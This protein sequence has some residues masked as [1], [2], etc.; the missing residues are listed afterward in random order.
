MAKPG[1]G[2]R[3]PLS[4]DGSRQY[5]LL[6]NVRVHGDPVPRGPGR[7]G[8]A[9]PVRLRRG[10]PLDRSHLVPGGPVG[11]LDL[12][13][14]V[15]NDDRLVVLMDN[16]DGSRT[17]LFDGFAQVPEL[18]LSPSQELVTFLAFG[19]AVREWD[20][21]IG[22]ALM[23]DADDPSTVADVETD[24]VTHF[25]PE[26]Q[27]N[28]TPEGADA[29]DAFGNTYPTFLDPL[30]VR[31]PDVRRQWTLPMAVRYLCYH[32][33]PDQDYVQNPDGTLLDALLDSRAPGAGVTFH[34]DDPSTYTSEPIVVPDYP[35]HRQGL[36]RWRPR[37]AR[38]QRLRDGVPARDRRTGNPSPTSTSSAGRTL[39]LGLQGPLPPDA[40]VRPR[41]GADQPGPAQLARDTTGVA[42]AIIVESELVRYEASF[43]LAPGFPISPGDA[44]NATRPGGLRPERPVVL[45]TNHDKYRLYVFDETGEGHWDF[46]SSSMTTAAPSLDALLGGRDD[47]NPLREA[48]PGPARRAVLDRREPE[49][50]QGPARDLDRLQG[51]QP[52]LWDGTGTWQNVIGGFDL[53]KDRLGIWINAPN[54][55]GWNIGASSVGGMPYPAGVVKGVEDQANAGAPQFTLRLTCVIEGDHVLRPRPIGGRRARRPS[56][57]PGGSTPATDISSTWSPRTASSTRPARPVVVRDDT[58]DALAEADARG[59]RARRARS[60]GRSRSRGSPTP[61]GSATGSRSI[62][63]RDLSLR[64]NAG[65]PTEEGEVFPAVVGLTW[66]FDG[67]QHTILHLSDHRGE[68]R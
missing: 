54:P 7:R 42:N 66:D 12:P 41:P 35:G 67:K 57:S 50:A 3:L 4:A 45:E 68:R 31:S 1:L 11:R 21:P 25:N 52:G 14:V 56:R 33:N 63:G 59:S 40:G 9:V 15:Q 43:V 20:T 8:R 26:G 10:Q 47:P 44:A 53:L 13:G 65:A 2:R 60:P 48:A 27:P 18:S 23:R 32:H 51:P 38:A 6:G 55:N 37:P 36:A 58:D 39:A 29:E 17:A 34:P 30:V 62:Q 5:E 61:T 46:T 16:P 24:L 28:A 22:G 64:T 19:V 49:A